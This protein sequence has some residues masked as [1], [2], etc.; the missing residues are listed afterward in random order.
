MKSLCGVLFWVLISIFIFILVRDAK[1]MEPTKLICTC[2]PT[3]AG[4][5]TL[6]WQPPTERCNGDAMPAEEIAAYIIRWG[7]NIYMTSMLK[8]DGHLTEYTVYD[9]TPNTTYY[10]SIQ[11]VDTEGRHSSFSKTVS[12][13]AE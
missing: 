4:A 1:A 8:V 5:V 10:F 12:V 13:M 6:S 3:Q 7:N 2:V 9:L 11:T